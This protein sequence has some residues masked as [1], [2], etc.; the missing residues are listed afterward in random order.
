MS[1]IEWTEDTLNCVTACS[2]ISEGCQH[3]YAE[4]M[5]RRLQAMGQEKYRNGF[6]QVTIHPECLAS[7]LKRKRPTT[8]F[9]N[10]MSDTF[11][12]DVSTEFIKQIFDTMEIAYWHQF[13]VLTKRAVRLAELAPKLP[14]SENVWMGV[15]VES[16]K[17]LGRIDCLRGV[18]A[19]TRFLSLEPLL[20]PIPNLDLSGIDWVIVGGESG[21]KARP[22]AP[23]WVTDIRDQCTQSKVSFFFKQ[24]GHIRNN[25]DKNDPTHK[26]NGGKSKGGRRLD[27][28]LWDEIPIKIPTMNPLE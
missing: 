11:H 19:A 13:Q 17:Y 5:T 26:K 25:P 6:D 2:K 7:I 1:K 4:T 28:R 16:D 18:P 14:W 27:G 23:E 15:T 8:Y 10:S 9:V 21:P 24:F 22:M 12:E 20:S 3:C